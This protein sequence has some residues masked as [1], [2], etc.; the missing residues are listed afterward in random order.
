MSIDRTTV[1]AHH[2]H[3]VIYLIAQAN[4]PLTRATLPAAIEAKLGP[5]ARFHT[6]A[7]EDMNLDQLL[8]FLADRGKLFEN[9]GQLSTDLKVMCDHDE[10]HEH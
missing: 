10:P 8:T 5:N 6:C 9:D 4:P 2:G 3:E 7:A 1:N